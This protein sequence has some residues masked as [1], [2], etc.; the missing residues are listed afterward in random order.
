MKKKIKE[1][2]A[3][4]MDQGAEYADVRWHKSDLEEHIS[5]FNGDIQNF[6]E[7][8]HQG[9]GIRVYIN[10]SWGF[11]AGEKMDQMTEVA[12]QAL[13]NAKDSTIES[14]EPIPLPPREAVI[15]TYTTSTEIDPFSVPIAE[16]VKRLLQIDAEL[17]DEKVDRR[18][19]NVSFHKREIL[20]FD[21]YGCEITRN[22]VDVYGR[23][24]I[25]G[26]DSDGKQQRRSFNL[27]QQADGSTGWENI[28]SPTQ[29]GDNQKLK[30]ELLSLLHAK[31]CEQEVCDIILLPEMMAL[32]THET[33]G[34]PLELDRILG[35]E[36]SFAG[37]SHVGLNDFGKLR[38]GS[39]KLNASANGAIKNSPGSN[40]FDDDG[41]PMHNEVL[42]ADGIL[43]GAISSRWSTADANARRGDNYFPQSGA[44]CRAQ[45]YNKLPIDRMNN[46]NIAF[47][48]D[49][50]LEDIIAK[51]ENG[52]ILESPKSWSIGSNRENFHFSCEIAWRVKDG[53]V[54]E[55][56]KNATYSAPSLEFWNAM[57][58]VGDESTWQMQIVFNCGKG[59]PNQIMRLGHG[60]P[61]A[62]FK[63]VQVG[64]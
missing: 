15:A 49:G 35:Y 54:T 23:K 16:K 11:A 21:S 31:S 61:I 24:E 19:I 51:T 50:T 4:L 39:D 29:F 17:A 34:H 13:T 38:F 33:I 26:T 30:S 40:G 58:Q 53:K 63:N 32:Q 2:I 45:S 43:Q 3:S 55:V 36:L 22:I 25:Y 37:G 6:D 9:Y 56:I 1:V 20:F 7:S 44:S 52:L 47:G 60:I 12:N 41:E 28:V 18:Q 42:I 62:R 14:V 59:Q 57:D 64:I 10:S 46:I 8:H 5:T 27:Y 48:N